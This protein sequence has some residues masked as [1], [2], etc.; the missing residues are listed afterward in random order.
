LL[1]DPWDTA[2]PAENRT[3]DRARAECFLLALVPFVAGTENKLLINKV[4]DPREGE[5]TLCSLLLAITS[6]MTSAFD[7]FL[8]G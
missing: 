7:F 1:K 3:P 5:I 4:K 2:T 6:A 8:A